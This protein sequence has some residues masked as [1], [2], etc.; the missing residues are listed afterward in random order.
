MG[1]ARQSQVK[2][3]SALPESS[4]VSWHAPERSPAPPASEYIQLVYRQ[5]TCTH[6][7]KI[8]KCVLNNTSST[9]SDR[10]VGAHQFTQVSESLR[11][12]C[13][14][15]DLKD[16]IGRLRENYEKRKQ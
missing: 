5:N 8:N 9:E 13:L 6:K 1:L 7:T 16:H 14:S 12:G 3:L 11:E 4:A 2:A 15:C 10:K